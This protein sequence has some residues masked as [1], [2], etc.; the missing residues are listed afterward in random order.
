MDFLH[1][2]GGDVRKQP[3][4]TFREEIVKLYYD[5]GGSASKNSVW[6]LEVVDIEHFANLFRKIS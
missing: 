3:F 1:V 5:G 6:A 2:D 4:R